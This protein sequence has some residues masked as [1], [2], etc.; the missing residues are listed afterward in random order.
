MTKFTVYLEFHPDIEQPVDRVVL[1][2]GAE[3]HAT[4]VTVALQWKDTTLPLAK[5]RNINVYEK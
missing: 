3:S 1:T 2:F 5:L 4:A